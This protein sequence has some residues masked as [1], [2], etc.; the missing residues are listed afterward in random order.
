MRGPL[1]AG[2]SG[3]GEAWAYTTSEP[4]PAWTKSDYDDTGWAH[5]EMGFGAGKPPFVVHTPW[6]SDTIWLRAKVNVPALRSK[7]TLILHLAHDQVVKVFVNG[8][9]ALWAEQGLIDQGGR[10]RFS[11]DPGEPAYRAYTLTRSQ[12]DRF[13]VGENVLA[14]TCH[15]EKGP[16]TR[17]VDLGLSL[18]RGER[19][20][21]FLPLFRTNDPG[22]WKK[23]P[24]DSWRFGGDGLDGSPPASGPLHAFL[25]SP[26]T[27]RNFELRFKARLTTGKRGLATSGVQFR[28]K[29]KGEKLLAVQGF[30]CR[31]AASTSDVAAGSL[32][33]E[34]GGYECS[35]DRKQ[36]SEIYNQDDI[37]EFSITCVGKHVTIIVNGLVTMNTEFPMIAEDGVIA[38]QLRG[39]PRSTILTVK[40]VEIR[41][42]SAGLPR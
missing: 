7:D 24:I 25:V 21:L 32:V 6:N 10:R 9:L 20:E 30:L 33:G 18:S 28:S 35:A 12:V 29:V 27:F 1:R 39:D 3:Q 36:V 13:T 31:I 11:R 38:W 8:K 16:T 17:G 5:G 41:E 19:S 42:L 15:Y 34:T 2:D 14:V 40:D 37:N 26:Q 22:G 4:G 23:W